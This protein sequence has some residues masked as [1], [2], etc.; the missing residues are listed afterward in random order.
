MLVNSV[1]LFSIPKNNR[2]TNLNNNV[3][4]G[5]KPIKPS[6]ESLKITG[7][8]V[9]RALKLD[10]LATKLDKRDREIEK[11][12]G[13]CPKSYVQQRAEEDIGNS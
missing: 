11:C 3:S 6:A 5:V 1:S 10:R 2:K 4:F 7:G 8:N 9:E 13:S 12:G